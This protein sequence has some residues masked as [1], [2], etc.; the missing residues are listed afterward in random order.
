MKVTMSKSKVAMV[1]AALALVAAAPAAAEQREG[2]ELTAPVALGFDIALL[3]A[4]LERVER[5]DPAAM[6]ITF[7]IAPGFGPAPSDL[8]EFEP[9]EMFSDLPRAGYSHGGATGTLFDSFDRY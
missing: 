7:D 4:A 8:G 3:E 1:A 6:P 2:F 5:Q 9:I